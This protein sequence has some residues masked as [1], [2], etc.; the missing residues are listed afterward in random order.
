MS[1]TV[2]YVIG[3]GIR[4]PIKSGLYKVDSKEIIVSYPRNFDFGIKLELPK[5]LSTQFEVTWDD[6]VSYGRLKSDTHERFLPKYEA[7][8]AINKLLLAFKL[9]RIGNSEGS[10]VRSVGSC[11]Q[12]YSY[13]LVDNSS[14]DLIL[15][16]MI[17]QQDYPHLMPNA[18]H[19][20]DNAGTTDIAKRYIDNDE[21]VIA[22]RIVRSFELIELGLFSESF[23]VSFSILDDVTQMM[24]QELHHRVHNSTVEEQEKY[25][26]NIRYNRLERY[27]N[28]CLEELHGKKMLDLWGHF[29][30]ALTWFNRLRNQ[31]AHNGALVTH[32]EAK[33]GLYVAL[34]IIIT[35]DQEQLL[36]S[37]VNADMYRAAKMQASWSETPP[38]WVPSGQ[39]ASSTDFSG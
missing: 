16:L 32:S 5:S 22:K 35:L 9:A 31:I 8:A 29:D 13:A 38:S 10:G 25:T 11:D 1:S 21:P 36:R 26:S 14:Q 39:A 2:K 3:L 23:L 28:S 19:P 17:Q 20:E 7:M 27:L 24:L 4:A 34:K 15:G 37:G 18:Q 33:V 30:T 6:P 12:L